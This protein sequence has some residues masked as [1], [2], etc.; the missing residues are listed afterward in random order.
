MFMNIVIVNKNLPPPRLRRVT[1]Q[2]HK[3]TKSTNSTKIR[4]FYQEDQNGK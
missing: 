4:S 2:V 1:L 3:S